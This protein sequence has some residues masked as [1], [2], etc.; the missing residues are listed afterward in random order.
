MPAYAN[1]EELLH[2]SESWVEVDDI[3]F[4]TLGDADRIADGE[5]PLPDGPDAVRDA[6]A[7]FHAGHDYA[8]ARRLTPSAA[9][10]RVVVLSGEATFESATSRVTLKRMQWIDVPPGGGVVRN[11]MPLQPEG[12]RGQTQLARIAG[13]WDEAIRTA[14]FMFGPGHPCDYHFHDGAEYWFI[15][16]GRF[17]LLL[18]GEEQAMGPGSILAVDQGYEHGVPQPD[19]IFEGVGFATQLAGLGRDGHLWRDVHGDPAD[20]RRTG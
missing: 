20:V 11:T 2:R 18:D 7:A 8:G 3:E 13:H 16:R 19:E 12:Y 10:E 5:E 15:F 6:E 9:H 14:V 1:R 4:F 17:T